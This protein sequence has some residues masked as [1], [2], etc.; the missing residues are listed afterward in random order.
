V[1]EAENDAA[2]APRLR[3][4]EGRDRLFAAAAF[5]LAMLPF[6]VALVRAFRD[7]WVPSGD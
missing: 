3:G 2:A 4:L 5:L 6:A 7:G 1:R